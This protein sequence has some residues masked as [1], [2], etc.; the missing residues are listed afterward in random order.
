[1]LD[2]DDRDRLLDHIGLDATPQADLDGLRAAHRAYV[3]HVPFENLAVQL[4]ESRPIDP[5]ALVDRIVAGGRGGYCFE[6][7][8]VLF[9]LLESLGFEVERREAI[10]GPREAFARGE[11][12]NH[13]ALVVRLEDGNDMIAEGGFGEGPVEPLVLREGTQE[14]GAFE[15]GFERDENG[16]WF[17]QHNHS[18]T[19]GFRFGDDAVA[20][21]IFAPEHLRLSTSPESGFV[22]TLTVQQPY[23]DRIVSLR[24]RTLREEGPGASEEQTVLD[25]ADSWASALYERFGIDP[26]VLGPER[27]ERL[28]QKVDAQHQAHLAEQDD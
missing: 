23:D 9:E 1:V 12:T 21:D 8:T 13:L 3:S 17:A 10:V 15:V 20:L 27:L 14:S 2:P 18:T 6:A 5:P 19:P 26:D 7:N 22:R 25:D 16:W 11:A 24:A 28:W 4:G